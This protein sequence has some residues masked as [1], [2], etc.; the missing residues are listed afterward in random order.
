MLDP[1]KPRLIQGGLPVVQVMTPSRPTKVRSIEVVL[2]TAERCNIACTYCY[3][4][5]G[6]SANYLKHPPYISVDAVTQIADFLAQGAMDLGLDQVSVIFHGGEPLMQNKRDFDFS[7]TTLQESLRGKTNLRLGV[8]TNGMLIT[9]EWI[10]LFEKHGVHVGVS[11]DGPEEWH[12]EFRKDHR[13]RGTHKRTLIGLEILRA[14]AEAGRIPPYGALCVIDPRRDPARLFDYFRIELGIK[15]FDLLLPEQHPPHPAEQYGRFLCDLLDHWDA[16]GDLD[17]NIR[18]ISSFFMKMRGF[19]SFS[20]PHGP[21]QITHRIFKI[22][23]DGRLYPDDVI[24]DDTWAT[25]SV[26]E[27]TLRDFLH[28]E[29][30][31]LVD[32][33][34]Q[35]PPTG[36]QSCC[37]EKVCGGGHPWNRHVPGAGFDRPSTLCDGLK[38]FYAHAT[39]YLLRNGKPMSQILAALELDS[40][41]AESMLD[42]A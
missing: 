10:D 33:L 13:G 36:C 8:Q 12:D 18:F 28:S 19:S 25:P 20:F 1:S 15:Q 32:N 29:Y 14:A 4:F 23:S 39:A 16:C 37:W 26:V 31:S 27:T 7:C 41:P 34:Y 17:V 5:F 11:I 40:S 38:I 6:E 9:P 42:P 24:H 35:H 2:K 3:F 22:S 30:F 21:D